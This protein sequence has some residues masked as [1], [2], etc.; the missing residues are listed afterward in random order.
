[1]SAMAAGELLGAGVPKRGAVSA[2]GVAGSAGN[3]A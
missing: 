3:P 1:M 2:G